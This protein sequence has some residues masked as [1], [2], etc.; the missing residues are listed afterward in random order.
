MKEITGISSGE[1][2]MLTLLKKFSDEY[3]IVQEVDSPTHKDGNI[4]DLCFTNN[5]DIIYCI[6]YFP[7]CVSHH[8][9][10]Q[11]NTHLQIENNNTEGYK[12]I[13]S[14]VFE[15]FNVHY[16]NFD[17]NSMKLELQNID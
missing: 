7:N 14:N 9:T 15:Y 12:R 8:H 3:L 11:F 5:R 2:K 16:K 4:L 17:W 10:I 6:E 13:P 1:K